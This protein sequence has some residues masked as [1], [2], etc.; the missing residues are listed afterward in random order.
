MLQNSK[1]VKT[2]TAGGA[3]W[4]HIHSMA[5]NANTKFVREEYEMN[6][7]NTPQ[8]GVQGMKVDG[9]N[10]KSS[11]KPSQE[12]KTLQA[13]FGDVNNRAALTS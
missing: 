9:I 12:T 2:V 8:M 5:I 10:T 13:I 3:Q 1:N 7:G 11:F 4:Q 6:Q